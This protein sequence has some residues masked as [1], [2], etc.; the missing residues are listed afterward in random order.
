[1]NHCENDEIEVLLQSWANIEAYRAHVNSRYVGILNTI[2]KGMVAY[3]ESHNGFLYESINEWSW[4][5]PR[6][7]HLK[8][9]ELCDGET[10]TIHHKGGYPFTIPLSPTTPNHLAQTPYLMGKIAERRYFNLVASKS[11]IRLR[12]KSA[13]D[14][15]KLFIL[16]EVLS[17][18]RDSG[19][20]LRYDA[21]ALFGKITWIYEYE[22]V[23]FRDQ[24]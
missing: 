24:P 1:M 7:A 18:S 11:M 10:I 3:K 16:R 20:L 9:R 17:F 15:K 22:K 14:V 6:H 13:L 21:I 19:L 8:V 23:R 5:F 12:L 4:R 2:G